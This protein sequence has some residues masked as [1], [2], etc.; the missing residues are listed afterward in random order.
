MC[1]YEPGAVSVVYREFNHRR[2]GG[3]VLPGARAL[4]A[5]DVTID[6]PFE[7]CPGDFSCPVLQVFPFRIAS[8]TD[9]FATAVLGLG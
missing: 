6:R 5:S 3:D 8:A 4:M 9:S 7:K 2:L 1:L